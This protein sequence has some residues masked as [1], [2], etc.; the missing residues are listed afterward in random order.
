[1]R[2]VCVQ[3]TLGH[4]D[5]KVR[6]ASQGY[7]VYLDL[8]VLLVHK[9]NGEIRVTEDQKESELRD[10]WDHEDCQV[11]RVTVMY[12]VLILNLFFVQTFSSII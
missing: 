5:C 4:Q 9:E 2:Y 3:V 8:L 6:E 10:L 11:G 12:L 1:V 7:R